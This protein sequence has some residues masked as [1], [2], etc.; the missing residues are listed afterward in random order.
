MKVSIAKRL[1]QLEAAAPQRHSKQEE[2]RLHLTC[3]ALDA[4]YSHKR[5]WGRSAVAP[6]YLV[7]QPSE[8]DLLW[9]RLQ[10]NMATDADRATLVS[11]PP[12]SIAPERLVEMLAR[13]NDEI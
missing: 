10:A 13:L 11:L 1:E 12:C 9:Q 8:L 2:E 6:F 5:P 7:E 4:A 3:N